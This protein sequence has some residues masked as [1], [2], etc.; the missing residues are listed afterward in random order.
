MNRRECKMKRLILFFF[1]CIAHTSIAQVYRGGTIYQIQ[2][3][4]L[5]WA[6]VKTEYFC[7]YTAHQ[8]QTNWCWAACTQMV[9][10]YQGVPVTQEEIVQRVFGGQYDRPGTPYD[11]LMGAD[12]W[13]IKGHKIVAKVDNPS[14]ISAKSLILDLRDKYPLIIGL[15]MPGQYVG[16]AY[17]LTGI[18][19][20]VQNNDYYPQEVI[21]RDPW[22]ESESRQKIEWADFRSRLQTVVHIYPN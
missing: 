6:A 19:F 21:V 13:K 16:H 8:R 15:R 20:Y 22:P 3:T 10:N 1:I 4:K 14:T 11:I 2:G 17:V 12:G 18:S 7:D 5:Y 9:L